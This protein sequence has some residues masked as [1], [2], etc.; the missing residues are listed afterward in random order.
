MYNNE[1]CNAFEKTTGQKFEIFYNKYKPKLIWY[2]TRYTRDQEKSEDFADEAFMQGLLKIESFNREKSQVHTWIYKI[3]EN[4]VKKDFKERKRLALVSL[5]K[6]NNDNFDLKSIVPNSDSVDNGKVEFD[7]VN[8]KKAEIVKEVIL[9]LPEKYKK[10]MI[11]RE[12]EN[13]PYLEIAKL[14]SKDEKISLDGSLKKM[15]RSTD[16]LNLS[17]NNN[18]EKNCLVNFYHN[19]REVVNLV[20]KPGQTFEID[21]SQFNCISSIEI[22]GDENI[23]GVYTT[24]TNLSTIKSQISQGRRLIQYMVRKKFKYIDEHGLI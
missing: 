3:G 2:L 24:S 10:V 23:D 18:G 9:T 7:N 14:C 5:D 4:L 12:L 16:F 11:L 8:S 21:N 19:E 13:K 17:I 20:I 6:E 22:D 1:L 15:P